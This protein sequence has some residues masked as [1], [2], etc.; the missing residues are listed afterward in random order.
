MNTTILPPLRDVIKRYELAA[1]KSLGQHFL[2]D[3]NITDKIVRE[4]GDLT[5]LNV[6]E[7]G[8]GPGGLT[9]SLL[10]SG[11]QR[12]YA[13]EKDERCVGALQELKTVYGDRLTIVQAD[14]LK[15]SLV[16]NV[17]AP[18]AIV[19]NLPYNVGTQLLLNWLDDVAADPAAYTHMT[20]M[21]QKEVAMRLAAEPNSK[22]YG[23]LSVMVQWLCD[24]Y[25][26]FDLPAGAFTPP[27]KVDSTVVQVTPLKKPR[28]PVDRKALEKTLAAAFGN[29]RKMLRSSLG[30]L[31]SDSEGW[32][33]RS[34]IDPTRRAETLSVEEFCRLASVL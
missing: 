23:R 11:A 28:Y 9:R 17:P 2:L 30:T 5:G 25:D 10:K 13:V 32:L 18:R 27:P 15:V 22:Q 8:P 26:C 19:A 29:R 16:E 14:A 34:G 1:K 20:L 3:T 31:S 21:F 12:V 7:I 4:S 24:V 33:K 6:I